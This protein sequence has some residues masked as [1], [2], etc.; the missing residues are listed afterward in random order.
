[1]Y[2]EIYNE[3]N[4]Y[5]LLDSSYDVSG[6]IMNDITV[7][8]RTEIRSTVDV[9]KKIGSTGKYKIYRIPYEPNQ[10]VSLEKDM[11]IDQY[12]NDLNPSY[13]PDLFL[14]DFIDENIVAGDKTEEDRLNACNWNDWGND[15]FDGWGYFY[16]YDVTTSKY[17]FPLFNPMNAADGVVTTQTFNAFGRTFT[18]KHGYPVHAVFKFEIT[19]NDNLPFRFGAYGDM[20]SDGDQETQDYTRTYVKGTQRTLYYRKDAEQGDDYEI[21]WTYVS[22]KN[23]SENASVPYNV[24][25]NDDY[26]SIL[27]SELTTGVTVYFAKAVDMVD[28]V[29]RDIKNH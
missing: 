22:P 14:S 21:L 9:K 3:S 2:M 16:L 13:Y 4:L 15:V 6:I 18:I 7:S 26:M 5:N 20:G 25:Y 27:T 1:M 10:D 19:V 11:R 23:N 8:S 12:T 28:W 17:Y 24:V 29:V